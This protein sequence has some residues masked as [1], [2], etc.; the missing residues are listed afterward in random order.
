MEERMTKEVLIKSNKHGIV[1]VLPSKISF[2]ELLLMIAAKFKEA[3]NFFKDAKMA[4]AFEGRELT[5]Q[6]EL[7][8]I[9]VI[10][11][12]SDIRIVSVINPD[13]EMEERMRQRVESSENEGPG[14]GIYTGAYG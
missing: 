13:P 3:G 1:L 7:D 2:D 8:I 9:E 11:E 6:Q 5:A 4:I 14:D 10:G 12:N